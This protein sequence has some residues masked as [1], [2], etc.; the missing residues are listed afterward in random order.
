MRA[1]E[2]WN[3]RSGSPTG[4]AALL[5]PLGALYARIV[6]FRRARADPFRPNAC[7]LCVGNL[8]VGGSGKTPIAIALGRLLTARGKKIV[9]LTR[10]YG[11]R[12]RG[13]VQVNPARHSADD[14]GDEALLLVTQ[15]TTIV[16][17]NRAA[18]ARLADSMRADAVI[19]DDGFQNFQIAKDVSLIVI[20]AEMGFGNGLCLPAGPL[21]EPAAS[22]LAR[23]DAVVLVGPGEPNLPP[24]DGPVLRAHLVPNAPET[25]RGRSVFAFAG[26]GRPEKFFAMLR[27]IGA[28]IE[29]AQA[30]PDHH[31]F[32]RLELSALKNAA[33]KRGALLVTTEKDF[34]RLDAQARQDVH[35]V[36]I[37]ASFDADAALLPVLRPLLQRLSL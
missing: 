20:D 25:V 11:G 23:A 14:I 10:G 16:A 12:L 34:V 9:F 22:G 21:R 37:H 35:P 31:K 2:F 1:P 28:H 24:F 13:P 7:I 27:A 26:I 3:S 18:G 6:R 36:P 30:F 19:M 15:G 8:T 4:Y 32:T 5:S 29:G 33:L 17:R